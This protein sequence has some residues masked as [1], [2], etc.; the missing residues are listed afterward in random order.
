MPILVNCGGTD[1]RRRMDPT[2]SFAHSN[3]WFSATELKKLR[4]VHSPN[5]QHTTPITLRGSQQSHSVIEQ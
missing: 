4:D 1:F 2:T 3:G 5:I